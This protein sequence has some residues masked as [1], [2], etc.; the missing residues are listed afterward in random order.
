MERDKTLKH[1]IEPN[2]DQL[3]AG[4]RVV[5]TIIITIPW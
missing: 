2:K 4:P 1:N 3:M 5:A